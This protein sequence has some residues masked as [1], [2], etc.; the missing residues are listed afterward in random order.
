M[1]TPHA[2]FRRSQ[3]QRTYLYTHNRKKSTF[4]SKID[5]DHLHLYKPIIALIV[6]RFFRLNSK[7]VFLQ[8]KRSIL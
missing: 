3:D 1:L 4:T 2:P 8:E 7:Q 6:E 5:V